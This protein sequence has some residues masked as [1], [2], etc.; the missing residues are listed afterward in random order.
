VNC[1]G[2]TKGGNK[3]RARV[4]PG[5]DWCV[6]HS[7]DA[8]QRKAWAAQGG[9]NSAAKVRAKAALP[10]AAMG[11]DEV[12]GWLAICFRRLIAERMDPTLGNAISG[13]AKAMLAVQAA[14]EIEERLAA[15]ERAVEAQGLASRRYSA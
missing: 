8:A 14:S 15:L 4:I 7:A 10:A 3:C 9:T 13:M 6:F 11:A 2:I 5:T 12:G 1:N